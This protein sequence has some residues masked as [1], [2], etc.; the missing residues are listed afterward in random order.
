MRFWRAQYSDVESGQVYRRLSE[1]RVTEMAEVM[2]VTQDRV[3]IP[4][5]RY[6]LSFARPEWQETAAEYRTLALSAF[7]QLYR[8]RIM[9]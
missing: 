8:E 7:T 6:K 2:A 9:A 4:H 5:V 1:S 3:G